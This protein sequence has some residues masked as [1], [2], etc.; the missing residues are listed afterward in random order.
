MYEQCEEMVESTLKIP[1][2]IPH[3]LMRIQ[4]KDLY[5]WKDSFVLKTCN[6]WK[7]TKTSLERFKKYTKFCLYTIQTNHKPFKFSINEV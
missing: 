4:T 1:I 6:I 5:F 3:P 2:L 7:K